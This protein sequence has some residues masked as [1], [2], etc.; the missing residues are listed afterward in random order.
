MSN[1]NKLTENCIHCGLC[2]RKCA[3][4]QKY[5]LDLRSFGEHPELAYHCFLCSDCSLVCPKKIDGRAVALELRRSNV[6]NNGGKIAEKGYSA[7]IAEKKNYLFRNQKGAN[8]KSVLFPG[9]NFPS[10]F[11]ETTAYLV[12][13]LKETADIG[14]LYDCCGKPVSELGLA[15]EEVQGL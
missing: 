6:D 9:C 7:L 1:V 14:V 4:L 10:F 5:K 2:T 11:P 15:K 12:K 13:L 8:R 3:F